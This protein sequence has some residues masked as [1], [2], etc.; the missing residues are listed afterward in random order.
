MIPLLALAAG[1]ALVA[2]TPASAR[3][4]DRH[5]AIWSGYMD[6]AALSDRLA[7]I[8]A[9][10]PTRAR[11]VRVGESFEGR[12]IHA[13][14]VDGPGG[15]GPALLL[16]AGLDGAHLVGT[17]VAVRA[18]ELLLADPERLPDGV[19]LIVV[20]RANPDAAERTLSHGA[21]PQVFTMR[22][23]DVDRDG[24]ADE[25]GPNDLDGDGVIT[26]MRI[27]QPALPDVATHVIDHD[28]PRLM[29]P[30]DPKRGEVPTH[31][32][33]VES[34]DDDGDGLFAE[35]PP[36]GVDLNRNWSHRWP[37]HGAGA[38]T[39]PMS[40]PESHA[41]AEFVLLH[42]EIAAALTFGRHDNLINPPEGRGRDLNPR[43]PLDLEAGDVALHGELASLFRDRTGQSRAPRADIAGSFHAWIYAQRG[44]M[45]L[46]TVVWGRPDAP[47][48]PEAETAP[49][50][51]DAEAAAETNAADRA[52]ETPES[53][54][55]DAT[56]TP[57]S[58]GQTPASQPP[59]PAARGQRGRRP[60]STS[61]TPRQAGVDDGELAEQREWLAYSDRARDGAG[62]VPWAAFDHPQL[63]AVE[64]GG[65]V[66]GFRE[67]P[68]ADALDELAESHLAFVVELLERL[69]RIEIGR[70]EIE[71]LADTLW[72]VR[73]AVSNPARDGGGLPFGTV[74]ARDNGAGD[75]IVLRMEVDRERLVA[76]QRV[77][78]VAHLDSGAKRL[79]EW[80]VIAEEGS[81][82]PLVFRRPGLGE[83]TIEITCTPT[84]DR[85]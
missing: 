37:E 49:D 20:P 52:D 81:T 8:V 56:A 77:E 19:R 27:A 85:R 35:D 14:V 53:T 34:T 40:E 9:A 5:A 50:A 25:D 64:I 80:I 32:L 28:E 48:A 39:H 22:P 30:A 62:F 2:T 78:R 1:A 58:A 11:L 55:A 24:S 73:V 83:T 63:G 10:H 29:R 74:H 21:A 71:R 41:L 38:G 45:S 4:P 42:R 72:S 15:G 13:L 67:N 84:G 68:P 66:A 54:P 57:P 12:D 60:G 17:E 23:V 51:A 46:A 7:R 79:F 16:T 18:V 26:T 33:L 61:A 36:G 65:W 47:A 59:G 70:V 43:V 76:G 6:D 3:S 31:R 75:A 44:R 69:P 82:V